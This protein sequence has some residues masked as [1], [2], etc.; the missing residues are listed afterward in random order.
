MACSRTLPGVGSAMRRS[1]GR[2]RRTSSAS[3]IAAS[4]RRGGLMLCARGGPGP[5]GSAGTTPAARSALR[6][7]EVAAQ[8]LH[9]NTGPLGVQGRHPDLERQALQRDLQVE[10]MVERTRDGTTD[11]GSVVDLGGAE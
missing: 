4:S 11:L 1:S 5:T 6:I 7:A 8:Q 9:D 2:T 10:D 3:L